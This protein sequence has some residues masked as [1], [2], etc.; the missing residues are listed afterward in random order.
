[1]GRFTKL[2]VFS[3][4]S[5]PCTWVVATYFMHLHALDVVVIGHPYYAAI[6]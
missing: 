5:I 3:N 2:F 4:I 6:F 1:M